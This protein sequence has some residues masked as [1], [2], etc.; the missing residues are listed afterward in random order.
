MP[1]K[2]SAPAAAN[3]EPEDHSTDHFYKFYRANCKVLE[4]PVHARIKEM[5]E[6]F[7]EDG[8]MITKVGYCF[9]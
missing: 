7:V 3:G 6:K 9:S 2:K 4:I 8:E 5:Y 1:P